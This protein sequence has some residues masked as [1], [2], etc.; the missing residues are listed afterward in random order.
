[1]N[2]TIENIEGIRVAFPI[3]IH[4]ELIG[5][6]IHGCHQFVA[7]TDD[8]FSGAP[9]KDGGKKTSDFNILFYGKPVWNTNGIICNK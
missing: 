5:R 8:A 3:G 7:G 4:D 1:M 2:K 9:G 6:I